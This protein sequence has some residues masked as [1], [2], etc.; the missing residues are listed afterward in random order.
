MSGAARMPKSVLKG[1]EAGTLTGAQYDVM[2]YYSRIAADQ[3]NKLRPQLEYLVRL[4]M[5]ASDECGGSL[6]PDSVDWSIEFNPLWLVDS[7]TD[8]KIRNMNAQTDQIY[9]QN[10]VQDYN[11]VR[12]ARFGDDGMHPDGSVDTDSM[13]EEEMKAA[14][15]AYN[16]AH[17]GD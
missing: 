6:D 2:N 17:G 9:M 5:K 14:V 3:E 4:L 1:Q 12:S 15:E 10:G 8:A 11:E 13:S 7:E 16:K